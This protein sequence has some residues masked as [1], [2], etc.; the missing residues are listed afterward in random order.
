MMLNDENKR[1][2]KNMLKSRGFYLALSACVLAASVIALRSAGTK[3]V[4][5]L[6]TEITTQERVTHIH[7][8]P[9]PTE[10]ATEEAPVQN[11]A[12][13]PSETPVLT[14]EP[15]TQAVFDNQSPTVP[16]ESAAAMEPIRYQLPLGVEI[17][18]DYSQG[19][20]VFSETMK[21]WRTHN[22]V[23]FNGDKG[24]AVQ[25]IAPGT[26]TAVTSDPLYGSS[27]TVDHGSGIVSTISGLAEAGLVSVG[28]TLNAGDLIGV[29]GAVPIEKEDPAHIHLEI[30]VNGK[31]QDP[32]AVMGFVSDAD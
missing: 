31:L 26:V 28:T 25:T 18:K 6:T 21:D 16:T 9:R 24:T 23:D 19:V 13:I 7:V 3:A 15:E 14:P 27:V 5:K 8:N 17:G 2:F 12:E 4:K 32:L 11:P 30:R 29:V 20:P 10:P 1:S 22:G